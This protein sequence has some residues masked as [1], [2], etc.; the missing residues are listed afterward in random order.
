MRYCKFLSRGITR[1]SLVAALMLSAC[2]GGGTET[3]VVNTPSG[4]SVNTMSW[5]WANP[6]PHGNSLNSVAWSG[7]QFVAVG[8]GGTIL[9]SP[10][11]M[12]WTAQNSGT[13]NQLS[14]I[15]WSGAQFVAVGD[16]GN[17][18]TSPDGVTWTAQNSGT[19]N[20][21]HGITWSGA[22]FV[23]VGDGG[24]ILTSP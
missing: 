2:N 19:T 17:I 14:G 24:T 20:W 4:A 11:G 21:F 13:T 12:T 6:K 8:A 7:T 18:L 5:H 16:F 10:D 23:A 15:T 9:T 22:Q 3:N 1:L